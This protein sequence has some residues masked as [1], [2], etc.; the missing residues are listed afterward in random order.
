MHIELSFKVITSQ[1]SNISI[2]KYA[3]GI[4]M[5]IGFLGFFVEVYAGDNIYPSLS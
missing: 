5:L 4:I 2:N 3:A 1:T